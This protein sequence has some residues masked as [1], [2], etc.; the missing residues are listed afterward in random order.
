MDNTSN[1][2]YLDIVQ[3]DPDEFNKKQEELCEEF[4]KKNGPMALYKIMDS[5]VHNDLKSTKT[6]DYRLSA[7]EMETLLKDGI[8]YKNTKGKSFGEGYFDLYNNDMPVFVTSDSMLHAF[9]NFYQTWLK[10]IEENVMIHKLMHLTKKI[11]DSLGNTTANENV[12]N[13]LRTL[14]AIFY[15]PYVILDSNNLCT[16]DNLVTKC[17]AVVEKEKLF[18]YKNGSQGKH[19]K[20]KELDEGY[21]CDKID[22]NDLPY[23]TTAR[24]KYE[25]FLEYYELNKKNYYNTLIHTS[26]MLNTAWRGFK[27]QT[28]NNP[29]ELKFNGVDIFKNLYDCVINETDIDIKINNVKMS[30]NGT[31][32]KPRGH[33]TESIILSKYF[34]A[35]TFLSKFTLKFSEDDFEQYSECAYITGIICKS[36]EESID[37]LKEFE[38]FISLIIGNSDGY[39][40]SSFLPILNEFLKLCNYESSND[41]RIWLYE[42]R[43]NFGKFCKEKCNMV[44]KMIKHGDEFYSSPTKTS[45]C[46]I[47]K[48]NTVDNLVISDFVEKNFINDD[49]NCPARKYPS[50]FDLVYTLFKNDDVYD[51]LKSK[52]NLV[53]LPCGDGYKY[54]KHLN[55][56]REKYDVMLDECENTLWKQQLIMLK[57]LTADKSLLKDKDMYPF[58]EKSWGLKQ[59]TT[60]VGDYAKMRHDNVLYVDE[61]TGFHC[62]CYYPD[63]MI[64]PVPTFWKEFAKL[65]N[66][67][68]STMK[69]FS[70]EHTKY[71][72]S[73]LDNFETTL[74]DINSYMEQLFTT[75]VIDDN[76]KEKLSCIIKEGFRGSGPRTFHG[77]YVKLFPNNDDAL[78]Y[79]PEIASMFTGVPDDRD[80]GGIVHI[81][82][83][84]IKLMYVLAKCGEEKKIF[85]GPTYSSYEFITPYGQRL[86][87]NEWKDLLKT[88]QYKPL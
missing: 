78:K 38:N 15:V 70:N 55:N 13:I 16:F 77:W 53:T 79:K 39:T 17:T 33:Y 5:D 37:N 62:E 73:I 9:H 60:Q 50:V 6:C 48:G 63:I 57:S 14:E 25:S 36:L 61:C 47:G 80:E 18:V 49:G 84:S 56:M 52:M 75:G 41:I 11:K 85:V 26:P 45:F 21:V 81:G 58:Y 68:K 20:Q 72:L 71:I 10:T 64:E 82:V 40:I 23:S 51:I 19:N 8:V 83:G 1:I 44:C 2:K 29:I 59:A 4:K 87:D 65:V 28:L 27:A 43:H 22:K 32:F 54:E 88:E 86:N 30:M 67:T 7:E 34:K 76:L 35:F 42:N 24:K 66:I 69:T 31:T 12:N 74:N 3:I 46:I